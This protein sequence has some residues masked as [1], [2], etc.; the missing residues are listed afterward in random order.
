MS[1]V[2]TTGSLRSALRGQ[3]SSEIAPTVPP[4]YP[5]S[6]FLAMSACFISP[7]SR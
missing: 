1:R 3:E 4:V 6:S 7:T 5:A 2:L